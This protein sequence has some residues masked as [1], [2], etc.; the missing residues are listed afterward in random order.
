MGPIPQAHAYEVDERVDMWEQ[1]NARTLIELTCAVAANARFAAKEVNLQLDQVHLAHVTATPHRVTR[2]HKLIGERPADAIAVYAALRGTAL[3]EQDGNRQLIRQGQLLVC[4][5]D[6]PL[7]RGFGHGLEELA[8]K[9][10]REAFQAQTGL[11]TLDDPLMFDARQRNDNPYARA[12]VR[13]VGRAVVAA[14]PVP[15][16]EQA[17]LELVA[18]LATGGRATSP[19]AHRA[20]ARAF[21]DDHLTDTGLSASAVAMGANISERHLSRLFA[22]AGTSIPRYILARRLE[23][24]HSMLTRCPDA[25]IADIASQC[26]FTSMANFSQA[27]RAR[28]GIRPS[29]ARS[30]VASLASRTHYL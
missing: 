18:V 1:H 10:P 30:E 16:D 14:E 3:V 22:D 4:D 28:F 26:G 19:L 12:L 15:A 7:V 6:R 25:L 11:T 5:V 20:A 24:A 13:V 2:D 8:V 9:V 29:E 17:V 27:F 23:L 21:I